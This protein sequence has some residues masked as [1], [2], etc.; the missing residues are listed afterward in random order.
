MSISQ[1]EHIYIE[2]LQKQIEAQGRYIDEMRA[3]K[4]DMYA[5]MMVLSHYLHAGEYNNA[6]EY[7]SK[8]ME[9]PLFQQQMF[10]DVGNDMVNALLS[11]RIQKSKSKVTVF[12]SGLLPENLWIDD[13]DLCIL[14]SNLISNSVEACE[15]LTYKEK[16]IEIIIEESVDGMS[17]LFKNPVE[18]EPEVNAARWKTTKEDKHN[19]GYGMR[20]IRRIV[21]KYCGEMN[22][23][24]KN[25]LVLVKVHLPYVAGDTSL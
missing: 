7:L 3:V 14:F 18:T 21:D 4:H 9:I 16:E 2:L 22:M 8:L 15:K 20:N 6:T 23:E 12:T 19:H 25:G 13:M 11:G 1:E 5:H 17:I 10:F 24:Y